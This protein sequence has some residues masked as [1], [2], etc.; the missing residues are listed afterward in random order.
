MKAKTS[1]DLPFA[2]WRPREPGDIYSL[3]PNPKAWEP[4]KPMALESQSERKALE[5]GVSVTED[6]RRWVPQ[7]KESKFS[8]PPGPQWI[9]WCHL[10]CGG[11]SLLSL[12]IQML[13]S[14]RSNPTVRTNVLPAMWASLIA[15]SSEH[16]INHHNTASPTA[17]CIDRARLHS[18][19]PLCL[20]L[21]WAAGLLLNA[22]SSAP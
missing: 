20:S 5:P 6:R 13:F 22:V 19:T 16:K 3:S 14:P 1:H 4:E 15:Q 17:L 18:T 2:S 12:L 10:H 11:C 9:G 8:L 21:T 7:P